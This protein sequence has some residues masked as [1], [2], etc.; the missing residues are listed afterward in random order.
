MLP[1]IRQY[2]TRDPART[3]RCLHAFAQRLLHNP[4]LLIFHAHR[5]CGHGYEIKRRLL[6]HFVLNEGY[7]R[8]RDKV[9][10]LTTA[11][12]PYT[13]PTTNP[14]VRLSLPRRPNDRC[15]VAEERYRCHVP[16]GGRCRKWSRQPFVSL[17]PKC[18]PKSCGLSRPVVGE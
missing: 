1:D 10:R 3:T 9:F 12:T 7:S 15:R 13:I 6:S 8:L 18:S 4:Y 16:S 17:H 11:S 5:R 14:I 2:E